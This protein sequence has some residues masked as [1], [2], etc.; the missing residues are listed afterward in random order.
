VARLFASRRSVALALTFPFA[1]SAVALSCRPHARA[2]GFELIPP[3]AREVGR[4]GASVVGAD[5]AMGLFANPAT[6]L[7]PSSLTDTQVSLHMGFTELCY[8]GVEV[9][10][11]GGSRSAGAQLPEQCGDAKGAYIPAVA[12][13][14]RLGDKQR[15]ALSLGF[16]APPAVGRDTHFGSTTTGTPDGSTTSPLSPARYMLMHEKLVQ[17]FPTLGLSWQP[18]PQ[19]RVGASFGWGITSYDFTQ[20][21]F[22]RVIAMRTPF[23]VGGESDVSTQISGHDNFVPRVQAGLWLK[24]VKSLPLELGASFTWTQDVQS[25]SSELRVRNLRTD[26][27][28]PAAIGPLL[29]D[30]QQPAIDARV[31]GVSLLSPQ[32]ASLQVGARYARKLA[33]PVGF[34]GDRLE[35]ERFDIEANFVASFGQN[36]DRFTVRV[37][38]TTISVPSPSAVAPMPTE[39]KLPTRIELE[40][41][42]QTQYGLRLGGDYNVL[43]GLF[44]VRAGYSFESDGVSKGYHQLDFT[45]F[46]RF[47][48]YAGATVRLFDRVDL[49]A[50]YSYFIV[51]DV[52]TS[53]ADAALR[54]NVSGE[55]EAGDATVV[56][57]GKITQKAQALVVQVGLHL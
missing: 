3:G 15:F 12:S 8:R 4:A 18:H 31:K 29:G 42:W 9:S 13:T 44:A 14:L 16:Y 53:V 23:L 34:I 37:P 52:T 55:P 30:L 1:L 45:P 38:D 43:P 27:Y 25:S 7:A 49:S 21:A 5:S 28:F 6:V 10:E 19:L 32:L 57:A 22:S 17:S 41:Q 51:P 54:R 35:S 56:N 26:Y 46:K 50:A 11:D 48:L 20:G 47:G 24:P 2:L 33:R 40:H 36:L 39:L